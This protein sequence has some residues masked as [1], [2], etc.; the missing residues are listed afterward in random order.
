MLDFVVI[1]IIVFL[2]MKQLEKTIL[3]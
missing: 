1:A 3:N 2:M